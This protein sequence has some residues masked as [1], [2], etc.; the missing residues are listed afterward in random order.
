MNFEHKMANQQQND[1]NSLHGKFYVTVSALCLLLLQFPKQYE[2]AFIQINY[3]CNS[4]LSH[5]KN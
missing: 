2:A 4:K 5:Q 1:H 3:A